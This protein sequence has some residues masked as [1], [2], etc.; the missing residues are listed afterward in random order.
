MGMKERDLTR[1]EVEISN[2]DLDHIARREMR[3]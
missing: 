1:F 3:T 2:L